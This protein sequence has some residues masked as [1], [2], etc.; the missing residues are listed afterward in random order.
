MGKF[1]RKL[2]TMPRVLYFLAK[3]KRARDDYEGQWESYWSSVDKDK[4]GQDGEVLWDSQDFAEFEKTFP[5]FDHL[6]D[7]SL[8]MLDL[9]CGNGSWSRFLAVRYERVIGVD[10]SS[11]AIEIA[12]E[13]AKELDNVEFQVGN[14][15]DPEV[16]KSLHEQYGEL[17]IFMRTVFHLIRN[18]DRPVFMRNLEMLLGENGVL[19]QVET[20][21]RVLEYML[22]RP[23]NKT[24][25]GLPSP[26]HK[27]IEHGILPHG[28]GASDQQRWFTPDRW[29]VLESGSAY[30]HTI[31]LPDG[32]DG[33]VPAHAVVARLRLS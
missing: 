28:F 8:P 4:T 9:G 17:N 6:A 13:Q 12:R 22:D 18:S 32:R 5:H 19:H 21:G 1:F 2:R 23:D 26:M 24:P 3:S 10:I 27:V 20:D 7:K 31:K 25:T 11:A 30:I 14:L 16:A 15:V 29:E 33:R